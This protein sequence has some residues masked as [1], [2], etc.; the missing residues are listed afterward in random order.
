M[1]AIGAPAHWQRLME[2]FIVPSKIRWKHACIYLDDALL[3]DTDFDQHLEHIRDLLLRS[4]EVRLQWKLSKVRF[5]LPSIKYLGHVVSEKGCSPDPELIRK[6]REFPRPANKKELKSFLSLLSY[7]RK[8]Y[9]NFAKESGILNELNKEKVAFVWL[10][11]HTKV[12]EKLR[13]KL[14]SSDILAWPDWSRAFR[15]QCDAS[16]FAIGAVLSQVD[17]KGAERP[18]AFISRRLS[19]RECNFDV[20]EKE[21]LAFVCGV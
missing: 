6:I 11:E 16:D 10:P 15:L 20:R 8:F 7:Y 1:G 13:D 21:C 18:V 17:A 9:K 2:T 3:Y 12:F 4:R 19:P 14:S 5:C